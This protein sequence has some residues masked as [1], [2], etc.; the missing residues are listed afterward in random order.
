MTLYA[1]KSPT[2]LMTEGGDGRIRLDPITGLNRYF[3]APRPRDVLAYASS[4][5]NDIS[6]AA[7]AEAERV[8]GALGPAPSPEA[9]RARLEAL[10]CRIRAAYGLAGDV[11][12]VFAPSGTDLEYVALACVKGQGGGGTNAVLL[13]ADEV[14]SGCIQSAHG[15]YFAEE[16]ALGVAVT[17]GDPVP[18]LG[19][20]NVDL[21]DIPV[22]DPEGRVRP[23]DEI[24]A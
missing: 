2:A 18:G 6:P 12:V 9:Y 7:Y 1:E 13:G 10:R 4:T 23:S 21:I 15:L 8:L 16:T 20:A 17:Q 5:A 24:A 22:R 3:S 14:G 11:A 19:G